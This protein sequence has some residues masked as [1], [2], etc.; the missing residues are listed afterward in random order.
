MSVWPE[1]QTLEDFIKNANRCYFGYHPRGKAIKRLS[2]TYSPPKEMAE[3]KVGE[4]IGSG[5]I[6]LAGARSLNVNNYT[7][8]KGVVKFLIDNAWS[9][10]FQTNANNTYDGRSETELNINAISSQ[11]D[12]GTGDHVASINSKML[13]N[14]PIIFSRSV[15]VFAACSLENITGNTS[16]QWFWYMDYFIN[17]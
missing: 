10:T 16:R 1:E 6:F 4:I 12:L 7:G 17:E 9:L 2:S 3:Q 8:N 11:I 13:I 15:E 5:I 14:Q